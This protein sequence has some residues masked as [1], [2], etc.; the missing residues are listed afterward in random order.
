MFEKL[1]DH[2]YVVNL[3]SRTDRRREMEAQLKQIGKSL[4]DPDVTLFPA[5]RPD[6]QGPFPSIGA[7]GCFLSH[8]GVL[9]DAET[10]GGNILILEDDVA[11]HDD[12]LRLAPNTLENLN[13]NDWSI[14]YGGYERLTPSAEGLF[15]VSSDQGILTT[16]CVGFSAN[17]VG[18]V[19]TYLER[20]LE[21]E[22]GDPKGGPMHVDGAYSWFR[23]D[24]P[25]YATYAANPPLAH[26]RSSRSDVA[27]LKWFDR[28]PGVREAASVARSLLRRFK[29]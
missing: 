7:R 18:P 22:P 21:R 24:N 2:I 19:R 4:E 1:F 23:A 20:M 9:K 15:Q 5:C 14:F 12:F 3:P 25:Q 16:H 29:G 11:L 8:L 17:A 10:R 6:S 13:A 27:N 26:Q 28:T